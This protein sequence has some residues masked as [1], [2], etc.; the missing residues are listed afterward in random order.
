M[1]LKYYGYLLGCSL[2]MNAC[3]D[4]DLNPLSNGSTENWYQDEAEVEMAVNE[5]YRTMFWIQDG[6]EYT[7]W[8]DDYQNRGTLREFENATLNGQTA[9]VTDRWNNM[10]KLVARA[11]GVIERQDL[12]I[13]N[14]AN[15]NKIN[16]LV[17]EAYFCRAHAY[18]E[19][20]F[21]WGDVPLVTGQLT[22]DEAF[23]LG[24][25]PKAEVLKLIYDDFD[26]AIAVLPV[27]S[28]G[29]H[30]AT[31]G[32]ALALKARIALRMNDYSVAAD[33][34]KACMDLN[35]YSLESDYAGMFYQNQLES[36]EFIFVAP[37]SVENDDYIRDAITRNH[38]PRNTQGF[39]AIYPTWDLFAAYTC[40]DGLPIDESPLFDS[41]D[42]FLNRDPR[43]SMTIVPFGINHLGVEYNP[44][45]DVDKVMDYDN[46]KMVDNLAPRTKHTYASWT[47]LIW[48][49]GIDRSWFD[50]GYKI[51]PPRIICRYADVLLM[52]AEAKIELGQIDQSVL[53]A[54]NK[55][56]ARAY[57]VDYT[58]VS[59]Y[60][61]FTTTDQS[62]L[63]SQLRMERRMEFPM[64]C[65]R[66]AD[67][68]RWHLSEISMNRKLYGLPYSNGEVP[69]A[70]KL[71][72]WFWPYA[73]EIDENGLADFSRFEAE[74]KAVS[75]AQRIW[76][77]R[78]Y[79]W[80]I[81]TAEI[82]IN[83]NMTQNPGY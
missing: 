54:M 59:Q 7:D 5:L 80:P 32:A 45:P 66:Y 22:I 61:A 37:R 6:S 25:T 18:S 48:R 20:V 72:D 75:L 14:G 41:H 62:K 49:K 58:A 27:T 42:P 76:D 16:I 30:R 68:I 26:H 69:T 44:R 17:G 81:P 57:G 83:P 53:D 38:F 67:L 64:E 19:L 82:V 15:A 33:A 77:N 60:P 39:C 63:R 79:L 31:K 3:H 78:M 52:Y 21:K 10:Y 35:A 11:N 34:A 28:T 8:S 29:M 51:A 50:N 12:A 73:P 9:E 55:V 56:R 23:Q 43:L 71:A 47:G 1:K 40:T 2:F 4:L 36:K 46:N 13:K 65:L 70:E 24:R 74:G